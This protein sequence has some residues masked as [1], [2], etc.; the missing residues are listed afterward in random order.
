MA[1]VGCYGLEPVYYEGE[2]DPKSIVYSGYAACF[3]G[4]LLG[5]FVLSDYSSRRVS[6]AEQVGGEKTGVVFIIPNFLW[7]FFVYILGSAFVGNVITIIMFYGLRAAPLGHEMA[8]YIAYYSAGGLNDIL[9]GNSNIIIVPSFCLYLL[10]IMFYVRPAMIR[11][12]T[13]PIVD[14]LLSL[15]YEKAS[16]MEMLILGAAEGARGLSYAEALD[17]AS[18][19]FHMTLAD[20]YGIGE[21]QTSIPSSL[22]ENNIARRQMEHCVSTMTVPSVKQPNSIDKV[23]LPSVEKDSVD[24]IFFNSFIWAQSILGVLFEKEGSYIKNGRFTNMMLELNRVVKK[25]GFV[26]VNA[27]TPHEV[28]T[29]REYM[30]QGG[31][32]TSAKTVYRKPR[33]WESGSQVANSYF[34]VGSKNEG[35]DGSMVNRHSSLDLAKKKSDQ[36]NALLLS[37]EEEAE[38]ELTPWNVTLLWLFFVF[39]SLFSFI[40]FLTLTIQ[41]FDETRFPVATGFVNYFSFVMLSIVQNSVITLTAGAFIL[42]YTIL[43]LPRITFSVVWSRGWTYFFVEYVLGM[44]YTVPAW[45][46]NVVI[47]YYFVSKVFGLNVNSWYASMLT[48]GIVAL[49]MRLLLRCLFTAE[50]TDTIEAN[51]IEGLDLSER[52]PMDGDIAGRISPK[53]VATSTDV[54]DITSPLLGERVEERV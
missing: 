54:V 31:F 17:D 32:K 18:V 37:M 48:A 34:V 36:A 52:V 25:E 42:R 5:F 41:Y 26:V 1:P 12:E 22:V 8:C 24:I 39:I 10:G 16:K 13:G 49:L 29:Y 9:Y 6:R 40:S 3:F 14:F 44:V 33:F 43:K 20:V 19:E 38:E 28:K 50:E 27:F 51:E 7:A 2:P 23:R 45:I 4:G 21:A 53:R 11:G 30:R 47:R 35:C 15:P 46:I